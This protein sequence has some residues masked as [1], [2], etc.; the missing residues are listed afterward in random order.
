MIQVPIEE[1]L[2]GALDQ[3]SRKRNVARSEIIRKACRS[4]LK[5]IESEELDK[6]YQR[7]YEKVPEESGLGEAQI[8][9]SAQILGKES[10]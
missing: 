1:E 7:G 10:W 8:E 6:L 5:Q 9:L 3:V 4:Y 2:L